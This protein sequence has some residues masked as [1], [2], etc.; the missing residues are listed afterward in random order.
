MESYCSRRK[1]ASRNIVGLVRIGRIIGTC[2][3]SYHVRIHIKIFR[4]PSFVP[5]F[6]RC[7]GSFDHR[8]DVQPI[9]IDL[10]V[11]VTITSRH[12]ES[13]CATIV[14]LRCE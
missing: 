4:H 3:F 6:D 13:L 9:N 14:A 12:Q 10:L 2:D 11:T 5:C 1:E 7:I 8:H